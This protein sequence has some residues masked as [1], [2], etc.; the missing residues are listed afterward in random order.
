M[1]KQIEEFGRFLGTLL[2]LKSEGRNDRALMEINEFYNGMPDL[3]KSLIDDISPAEVIEVLI[4]QK[5]LP[6]P[7][8]R[9]IS[10]LLYEEG[11]N[12]ALLGMKQDAIPKFQKCRLLIHYLENNDDT[13]SFEWLTK[14][15][16]IEEYLQ[17]N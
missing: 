3:N 16:R 6:L 4:S 1:L 5:Q 17:T 8:L 15:Q 11:D 13:F 2:K 12:L 9:M 7:K 14:K 10:D